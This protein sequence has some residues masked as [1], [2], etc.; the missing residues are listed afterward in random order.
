MS[1]ET[2]RTDAATEIVWL[3]D[4][5]YPY[6]IVR[7]DKMA[8]LERE[9]AEVNTE[10]QKWKDGCITNAEAWKASARQ[11]DEQRLELLKLRDEL[12]EVKTEVDDNERWMREVLTDFRI[13]FDDHK[14]GRRLAFTYWMAETKA[15]ANPQLV[16]Q[17]GYLRAQLDLRKSVDSD[18]VKLHRELA[19]AKAKL[20]ELSAELALTIDLDKESLV[21]GVRKLSSKLSASEAEATKW[22]ELYDAL[23]DPIMFEQKRDGIGPTETDV[24]CIRRI[25]KD[26]DAWRGDAEALAKALEMGADAN[27]VSACSIDFYCNRDN[28][29]ARHVELV[30]GAN[31]RQCKPPGAR[32][33]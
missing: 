17:T 18:N 15:E 7:P 23:Y 28:A 19:E 10:L 32:A 22:I 1:T 9:L 2:P 31:A 6:E 12:A 20:C 11:C 26:R 3:K 29:L 25:I 21:S 24:E 27:H 5:S 4:S 13:Q 33:T 8:K 30:K 16:L 14:V